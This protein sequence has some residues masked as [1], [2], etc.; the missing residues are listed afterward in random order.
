MVY[1][2]RAEGEGKGKRILQQESELE[3][4]KEERLEVRED[5]GRVDVGRREREHT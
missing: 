3:R 1:G 5:G 4:G 2:R